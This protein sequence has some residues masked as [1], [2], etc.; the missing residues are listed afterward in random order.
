MTLYVFYK[1]FIK[2]KKM[3][4]VQKWTFSLARPKTLVRKLKYALLF[5]AAAIANMLLHAPGVF[6]QAS[7]EFLGDTVETIN[8]N[9]VFSPYATYINAAFIGIIALIT[10]A[11]AFRAYKVWMARERGEEWQEMFGG[12]VIGVLAIAFVGGMSSFLISAFK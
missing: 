2:V 3:T 12:I 6:A 10:G 11:L 8:A 9:E 5:S 7:S 4:Q 1:S